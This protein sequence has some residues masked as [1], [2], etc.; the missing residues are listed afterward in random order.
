MT[1]RQTS[2]NHRP[3]NVLMNILLFQW[4]IKQIT[5][6]SGDGRYR[7]TKIT[8]SNCRKLAIFAIIFSYLFYPDDREINLRCTNKSWTPNKRPNNQNSWL[9]KKIS[10]SSNVYHL[11]IKSF[12]SLVFN[13]RLFGHEMLI[14]NYSASV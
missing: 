10:I 8:D 2:C 6:S 12:K 4:S 5:I 3:F 14:Y 9:Y 1:E 13:T 7:R 11:D